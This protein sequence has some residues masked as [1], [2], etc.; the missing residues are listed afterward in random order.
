ML[1]VA[2]LYSLNN[3]KISTLT[4]IF[5]IFYALIDNMHVLYTNLIIQY[6]D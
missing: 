1:V 5:Q 4:S 2:S 6:E 3:N